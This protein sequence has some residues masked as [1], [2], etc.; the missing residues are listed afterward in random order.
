MHEEADPG[1]PLSVHV[2]SVRLTCR[3]MCHREAQFLTTRVRIFMQPGRERRG[4]Q[5]LR[6]HVTKM[7]AKGR[8][9]ETRT[10][11]LNMLLPPLLLPEPISAVGGDV[12][13]GVDEDVVE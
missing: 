8:Q 5:N 4:Q 7:R 3:T 1:T 11:P 2:L 6:H 12:V 9:V 13:E 10:T